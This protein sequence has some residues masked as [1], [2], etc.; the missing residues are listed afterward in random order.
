MK[1][2]SEAP[3]FDPPFAELEAALVARIQVAESDLE[4]LGH[5]RAQASSVLN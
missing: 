2:K 3:A 1:K 5:L 4:A